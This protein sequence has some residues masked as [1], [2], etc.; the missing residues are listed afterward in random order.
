MGTAHGNVIL[1]APAV[2]V[3]GLWRR[4]SQ[5]TRADFHHTGALRCRRDA[6]GND[7]IIGLLFGR[8]CDIVETVLVHLSL[9]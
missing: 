2:R 8:S 3:M 7:C 5:H 4:D 6:W 1:Y 9:S